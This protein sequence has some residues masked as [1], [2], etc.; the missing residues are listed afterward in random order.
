MQTSSLME[1]VA[2][3]LEGT[4]LKD[5]DPFS[6]FMLVAFEASGLIRFAFLLMVWPIIRFLEM[7]GMEEAGKLFSSYI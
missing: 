2:F 3:E 6:Y 1:S 5:P 7:I 4:L